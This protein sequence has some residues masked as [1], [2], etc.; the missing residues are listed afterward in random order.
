LRAAVA[1][2][3][4]LVLT[5]LRWGCGSLAPPEIGGIAWA[6]GLDGML[7]FGAMG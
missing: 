3:G 6:A 4:F 5:V 7:A 2:S 1:V